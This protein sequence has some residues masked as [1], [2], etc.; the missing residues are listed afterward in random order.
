MVVDDHPDAAEVICML[1]RAIGHEC[2]MATTGREGLEL[3]AKHHVDIALLDIGLPDISGYELARRLRAAHGRA[4]FIAAITGW[5]EPGDRTSAFD[6]GFDRHVLKPASS[7]V[8]REVLCAAEAQL[9]A[10][11]GEL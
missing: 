11:A 7:N 2:V 1:L 3:A 5:G 6:A 10:L 4:I 8:I 9:D